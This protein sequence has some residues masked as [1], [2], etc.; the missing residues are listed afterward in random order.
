MRLDACMG[1]SKHVPECRILVSQS[2]TS[3]CPASGGSP[4]V[5]RSTVHPRQGWKGRGHW[6]T[7]PRESTPAPQRAQARQPR[8]RHPR[9]GRQQ[10]EQKG[11][12]PPPQVRGPGP[13]DIGITGTQG[14]YGLPPLRPPCPQHGASSAPPLIYATEALLR[15][16]K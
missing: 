11:N 7:G 16:K 8:G 10:P 12:S 1:V 3:H 6:G 9:Q 15:L 4:G 13:L 5:T 2:S 14:G